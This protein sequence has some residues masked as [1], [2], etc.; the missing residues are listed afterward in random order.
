MDKKYDNINIL[1]LYLSTNPKELMEYIIYCMYPAGP[2]WVWVADNTKLSFRNV[3][4]PNS[5][6]NWSSTSI[7]INWPIIPRS[8]ETY[9]ILE[10][11]EFISIYA[12]WISNLMTIQM[13]EWKFL[14]VWCFRVIKY[15][16][17]CILSNMYA[18]A[19][20]T[21]FCI[22][23]HDDFGS[24]ACD[25]RYSNTNIV[26]GTISLQHF[27]WIINLSSMYFTLLIVIIK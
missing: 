17:A 9:V 25:I 5:F 15:K 4:F 19:Y 20:H 13:Y 26:R 10:I 12:F 18:M 23:H 16:G 27:I 7:F 8:Q 6:C 1:T 2:E 14:P 21:D 11:N 3:L 24:R 22:T